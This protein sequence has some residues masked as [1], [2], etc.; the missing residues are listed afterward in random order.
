MEARQIVLRAL[1]A[2][3]VL[4]PTNQVKAAT[5]ALVR[6]AA[7]WP[8]LGLQPTE[9]TEGHPALAVAEDVVDALLFSLAQGEL[10]SYIGGYALSEAERDGVVNAL[11]NVAFNQYGTS[12]ANAEPPSAA[13][14]RAMVVEALGAVGAWAAAHP[15]EPLDEAVEPSIHLPD[16][17]I[18]HPP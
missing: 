7:Q 16:P 14:L 17:P 12:H 10:D 18:I 13:L 1:G 15:L 9:V 6:R 2:P 4:R 3:A 5:A 11:M 8:G